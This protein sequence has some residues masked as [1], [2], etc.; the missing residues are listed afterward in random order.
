MSKKQFKE[1]LVS[2]SFG[3]TRVAILEDRKLTILEKE[4]LTNK[5]NIGNIFSAKITSFE[6]SLNAYFVDYGGNRPGFLPSKNTVDK[7]KVGD[8][9]L[10]QIERGERDSKGAAVTQDISIASCNLVIMPFN[11]KAG[12]ISQKLSDDNRKKLKETLNKLHEKNPDIGVIIRTSSVEKSYEELESD[13]ETLSSYW[14]IIKDESDKNPAPQLIYKDNDVITRLV[15]DHIRSDINKIVI[16]HKETYNAIERQVSQTKPKHLDSIHLHTNKVPL[17]THYQIENEIESIYSKT[18]VMKS[19]ASLVIQRTE[20]MTTIDV[21]SAKSTKAQDIEETAY[22]TNLEAAPEIARQVKLRNIGGLIVVDF[23]DMVKTEHKEEV[24]KV[25]AKNFIGDKSKIQILK[26]SNFGLLEISRQRLYPSVDEAELVPCCKCEGSG[27]IRN[28]ESF[29]NNILRKIEENSIHQQAP[30]IQV[31]LPVDVCTFIL[32]EKRMAI[33]ELEE[34]QSVTILLIPNKWYEIPQHCLKRI[35][36]DE[37]SIV[38]SHKIEIDAKGAKES[39]VPSAEKQQVPLVDHHKLTQK[40]HNKSKPEANNSKEQTG[41]LK[42]LWLSVFA[43]EVKP[44]PQ[45]E[46]VHRRRRRNHNTDNRYNKTPRSTVSKPGN[47]ENK[48]H[49]SNRDSSQQNNDKDRDGNLQQRKTPT[50]RLHGSGQLR[51]NRR[52]PQQSKQDT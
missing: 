3:E 45:P 38:K 10:I 52:K 41:L 50:T 51:T 29:A 12:G 6:K 13:F 19:G 15:K 14:Q 49:H 33:I 23:I 47:Q 9:I 46:K 17:F 20:A 1:I 37:Q 2:R 31:Q 48:Q 5:M 34:R 25:L 27:Q 8:K 22:K 43:E 35:H 28:I 39:Y 4:S 36:Q 18:I 30:I 16:D 42:R 24:E 21:N 26:I 40:T 32:N 7:P 44:K 11:K